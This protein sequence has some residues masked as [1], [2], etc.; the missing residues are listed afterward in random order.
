[1]GSE[2]CIRDRVCEVWGWT[3]VDT[4]CGPRNPNRE[5]EGYSYVN[6]A[7]RQTLG[8]DGHD[9]RAD[10]PTSRVSAKNFWWRGPRTSRGPRQGVVR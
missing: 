7:F 8:T 10:T 4:L 6:P 5:P 2:M 3:V 9:S 1:M